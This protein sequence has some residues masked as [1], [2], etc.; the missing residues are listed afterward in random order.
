MSASDPST[1]SKD[2]RVNEIIAHYL[3]AIERGEVPDRAGLLAGHPDLAN[4]LSAFF[5]DHDRFQKGAVP[6]AEA[7]TLPVSASQAAP[8]SGRTVRYFGD[9]ELLEEIARGG[10]GVVYKARQRS[11]NRPVALKMI[12]AGQLAS[13]HDVKRF[14]SEAEAAATLDHPNIVPI[15]EVGQHEGQHYFTMGYVDGPSLAAKLEPAGWQPKEAAR[16]V[17]QIAEA[18]QYAHARGVIH[19]DLKP[20]NV[21]LGADGVPRITDFGLAK[22]SEGTSDLTATGQ[23]L[24]TPSYMSPEQAAG[25]TREIGPL[26]DVYSLGAILYALLT[27]RPPFVGRD[28][29]S[30][31]SQV[32][33]QEPTSPRQ[34]NPR[35]DRDMETI[36]L[37]CLQKDPAQR[38][39]SALALADDLG[40]FLDGV[41]IAARPVGKAER[42]LRWGRRNPVVATLA[43][44]AVV[45][46]AAVAVV[47]TV[48]YLNTSKALAE[49]QQERATS[50]QRLRASLVAQAEAQRLVG[51]RQAA[52]DAIGEAARIE[53]TEDLRQQAV[54][55]ITSP[56]VRLRYEITFGQVQLVRMSGDGAVLAVGGSCYGDQPADDRQRI[57]V[58]RVDDGE[59]VDQMEI[60]RMFQPANSILFRPGTNIL[61]FAVNPQGENWGIRL[62]DVSRGKDLGWIPDAK[63]VLFSPDSQ[64]LAYSKAKRIHVAGAGDVRDQCSFDAD[65]VIAFLS[66]DELLVEVKGALKGWDVRANRETFTF[67]IPKGMYRLVTHET[68]GSVVILS[69][70]HCRPPCLAAW[71]VRVGKELVR[72]DD[73]IWDRVAIRRTAPSSLLALDVRSRPGE[74][75]LYDLARQKHL[76]R[77][78]GV[79][80]GAG[81]FR[82]E[83]RA[84]LSPD[85]RLLAAFARTEKDPAPNTIR[86]WD[87]QT[88][89]RVATLRECDKPIWS[90]DGRHLATVRAGVVSLSNGRGSV[91]DRNAVVQVWDVVGPTSTYQ[92]GRP[93]AT[94]SSS[95]DG[96]RLAVNE[97]LWESGTV[98][99]AEYLKPL[100]CP[101]AADWIAF[102]RNGAFNAVE[103]PKTDSAGH[104]E[105]LMRM[106]QLEPLRRDMTLANSE[107]AEGI[108]YAHKGKLVEFSPDGRLAAILGER[109]ATKGTMTIGAGEEIDVWD[110]TTIKR[111]HVV[112]QEKNQ[113]SF[114]A[115]SAFST[116]PP[117]DWSST[118]RNPRQLAFSPDS[119]MLAAVYNTGAVVYEMGGGKPVRWLANVV[120]SEPQNVQSIP[121]HSAAFSPDGRW[122]Y[123]AGERGQINIGSIAPVPGELR[124][125]YLSI[126]AR[127]GSW[128]VSECDPILAW[129]GH[130]GTVRA[131]AVSPDGRIL[132]SGGD[133]RFIV[134]WELPSGRLLARWE[135][136]DA[137]ISALAFKPDGSVLVS[138]AADGLVKLWDLLTIRRE[139][140]ALGLDW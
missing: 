87:V 101:V 137:A 127:D 102:A 110:L 84:T 46:V 48:G 24:G 90:P 5:A 113:I 82:D 40:R 93:I 2:E 124:T 81:D 98:G 29:L 13:E 3:Q 100:P 109:M 66:N 9:Y 96:R 37:K 38:Y 132:A 67:A 70:W 64:K 78:D 91:A 129:K 15:F 135:A 128:K 125:P 11:L 58:Y 47:S 14:Y 20:P 117:S 21:L 111:L 52:L 112:Y 41:P 77:L 92:H 43:G 6:L 69:D 118:G 72:F 23:I 19:R 42:L 139:L 120:R 80:E 133:D 83:Q 107:A 7:L 122:I 30:T 33:F 131:L 27:G 36:T 57:R 138:G 123:Y 1:S 88:G 32:M 108:T 55:T 4:E 89:Q 97:C 68:I 115:N 25:K 45:L 75:L 35:V 17:R 116:P 74:I 39:T 51:Q 76:G 59:M 121:T 60:G 10:M 53:A 104:F 79:L 94:I 62:R 134:L 130:E 114:Q 103:L 63:N 65:T 44:T 28:L 26:T 86:V 119:K 31:I 61:A 95:R 105:P 106:H 54:Q 12:L 34:L 49:A 140:A 56:G 50:R 85:G 22:R 99:G 71:D 136:H 18:V 8:A 16:L 126:A 73:A